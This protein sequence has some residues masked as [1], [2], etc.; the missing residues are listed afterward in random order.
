MMARDNM[1]I[2][3]E[4]DGGIG[5]NDLRIEWTKSRTRDGSDNKLVMSL[6]Y[7]NTTLKKGGLFGNLFSHCLYTLFVQYSLHHSSQR[8]EKDLR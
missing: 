6:K 8:K 7:D 2:R 5:N 1:G 4:P 3:V